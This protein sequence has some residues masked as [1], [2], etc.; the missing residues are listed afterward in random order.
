MQTIRTQYLSAID[1]HATLDWSDYFPQWLAMERDR[2]RLDPRALRVVAAHG[3]SN[4]CSALQ[5]EEWMGCL[6]ADIFYWLPSGPPGREASGWQ[7]QF[8]RL[9][10]ES[11]GPLDWPMI[12]HQFARRLIDVCEHAGVSREYCDWLRGIYGQYQADD[13]YRR[14]LRMGLYHWRD[15]RY[16]AEL[17][18]GPVGATWSQRKAEDELLDAVAHCINYSDGAPMVY[19]GAAHIAADAIAALKPRDD[20]YTA[21]RDY[22]LHMAAWTIQLFWPGRAEI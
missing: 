4:F 7:T 16:W 13:S 19:A 14:S 11:A 10:V 3:M 22:W 15:D 2:R 6:A 17:R 5:I 9:F 8:L 12:R 20:Q 21:R 18:R 1:H